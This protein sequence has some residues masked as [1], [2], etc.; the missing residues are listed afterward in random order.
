MKMTMT[1]EVIGVDL[2]T[3]SKLFYSNL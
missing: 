2:K 1:E 3:N